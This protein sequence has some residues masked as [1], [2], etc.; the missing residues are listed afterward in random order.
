[1]FMVYLQEY[2]PIPTSY[3]CSQ[4]SNLVNMICKNCIGYKYNFGDREEFFE[5]LQGTCHCLIIVIFEFNIEI[6]I[7]IEILLEMPYSH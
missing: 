3:S 1:M 4:T 7:P 2:I 6:T 5:L